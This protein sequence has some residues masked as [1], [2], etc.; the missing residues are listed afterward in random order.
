MQARLVGEC[1]F[2]TS[3]ESFVLKCPLDVDEMKATFP[4]SHAFGISM[5]I[6]LAAQKDR[7]S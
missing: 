6:Q 2:F 5:S 3:P 4:Y 1:F 7:K